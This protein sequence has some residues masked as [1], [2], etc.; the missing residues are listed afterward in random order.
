DP[1]TS[2][3]D[4]DCRSHDIPNLFVCDGSV[5][6]SSGAG[7]PSLTIEAIAARTADRIETLVRDGEIEA[8]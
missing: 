8:G 3:V 5:F 6:P 1:H 7:N 4:S 2:V